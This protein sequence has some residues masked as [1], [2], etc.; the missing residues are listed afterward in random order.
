MKLALAVVEEAECFRTEV[1]DIKDAVEEADLADMAEV[2]MDVAME[3]E[4]EIG[5]VD[6][7]IKW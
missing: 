7:I 2:Y 3:E 6:N 4:G 5:A 1:E